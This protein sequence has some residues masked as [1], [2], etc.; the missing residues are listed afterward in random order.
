[1]GAPF[2]FGSEFELQYDDTFFSHSLTIE[3]SYMPDMYERG[4]FFGL[5]LYSYSQYGALSGYFCRVIP[6]RPNM[7]CLDSLVVFADTLPIRADAI[8]RNAG[9]NCYLED[10]IPPSAP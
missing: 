7:S 2:A 3:D 1:M 10:L 4:V 6:P 5:S 8:S 9:G